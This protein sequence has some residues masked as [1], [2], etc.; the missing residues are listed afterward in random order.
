VFHPNFNRH[1]A[2]IILMHGLGDSAEG[3]QDLAEMW[4]NTYPHVKF[5]LPSADR[6][7]V[8]L[9]GGQQ[10]NAWF[11]VVGLQDRTKEPCEG[12]L[13][14]SSYI[15]TL[16]ENEVNTT[17]VSLSRMMLAGFSQGGAM[18]LF[19]GLQL[20]PP[21]IPDT[22]S[23][24]C[25]TP[26]THLAGILSLSGFVPKPTAFHLQTSLKDTPVFHTHGTADQMVPYPRAEQSR[27]YI[28]DQGL[29]S[30]TL[31]SYAGAG[32]TISPQMLQDASA[33]IGRCLPAGEEFLLTPKHPNTM[34]IKELKEFVAQEGLTSQAAGFLYKSDF[35][36]LVKSF[37]VQH[38]VHLEE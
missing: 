19:T 6:R 9:A 27:Q 22:T 31:K 24:T 3:L 5:I 20:T 34:S 26:S 23:D 16:I 37:Y 17:G 8:G 38:G 11:D 33:F 4:G 18:S 29:T 30:Y 12:L 36:E 32:H 25:T 15:K 28:L 2:T 14:A 21:L 7:A 35:V 1:S 13:E 10:M